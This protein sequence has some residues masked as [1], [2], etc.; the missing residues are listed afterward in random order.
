MEIKTEQRLCQCCDK[1]VRG[2]SDK[3]FCDDYC[4]NNFNNKLRS[5]ENNL[6]RNINHVLMKNRRILANYLSG[7]SGAKKMKRELLSSEGFLFGYHTHQRQ[8][9]KGN[10][11]RF[12]YEYGYLERGDGVV[13][14]KRV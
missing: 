5:S 11:Y 8:S 2:R 6:I 10:L 4:R 9:R 3:K 14:V 13:I 1:P 7:A 12:C